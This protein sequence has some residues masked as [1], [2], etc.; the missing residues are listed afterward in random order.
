VVRILVD[1][2]ELEDLARQFERETTELAGIA[3]DLRRR[4]SVDLLTQVAAYGLPTRGV[5]YEYEN[6]TEGLRAHV[7]ELERFTLELERVWAE[8]SGLARDGRLVAGSGVPTPDLW[9]FRSAGGVPGAAPADSFAFA[10]AGDAAAPADA[11]L[12][13][14]GPGGIQAGSEFAA[15]RT[16]WR[17]LDEVVA[18]AGHRFQPPVGGQSHRPGGSTW[19]G[20]EPGGHARDYGVLETDAY[21]I[22]KLFRPLAQHRPDLIPELFGADGV[23]FDEGA[24]YQAP[25]H[26]DDHTHIAIRPG[27]SAEML[28]QALGGR[29]LAGAVAPVPVQ[30]AFVRGGAVVPHAQAFADACQNATGVTSYGTYPGHDPDITRALDIFASHAEGD[31][32]AEFAF[33]NWDQ[34][35]V[36]Y[37][38][39]RQRINSN[40]SR[41]WRGMADRGSITQNHYDHVHISFRA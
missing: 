41:G 18:A 36:M 32:V 12:A 11:V 8:A 38:I 3:L 6:L 37:V 10:A 19:H 15:G 24:A 2:A 33:A 34:F 27:V 17:A 21:D 30:E 29:L 1:V 4:M 23:G 40:D 39:W 22:A 13:A 35:R 5:A 20:V 25:G 7:G 26:T 14:A 28:L 9:W 16:G 31:A